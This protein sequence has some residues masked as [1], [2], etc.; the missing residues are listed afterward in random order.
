MHTK[1]LLKISAI[2]MCFGFIIISTQTLSQ[3]AGKVTLTTY[4]PAPYG[5][6]DKLSTN[7]M[8]VNDSATINLLAVGT[9][10]SMILVS[11]VLRLWK[12]CFITSTVR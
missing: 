2:L 9:G 11:P 7:Y 10:T 1:T 8:V 4:Y 12:T 3:A 5:V 6:Y